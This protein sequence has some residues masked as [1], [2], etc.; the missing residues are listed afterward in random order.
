MWLAIILALLLAT[1][2]G[3]WNGF[4]AA[5]LDI[6][7]IVVTLVLMV[8]GRG[9]AQ[10]VTGGQI[11]TIYYKPFYYIGC[12]YIAG[13]I[14]CSNI[15]SADANN[16][17]LNTELDAILAAVIG[18]TNMA[19]GK[20]NLVG[21]GV[22]FIQSDYASALFDSRGKAANKKAVKAAAK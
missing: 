5:Y 6:Q 10:L 15:K 9:I 14:V 4:L 12:G 19:G 3:A 21:S 8:A 20:F 22:C 18:G 7:P 13:L 17:G 2:L 1:A 16:A 11:V